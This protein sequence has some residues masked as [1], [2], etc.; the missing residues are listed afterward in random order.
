MPL[1]R[2]LTNTECSLWK[3]NKTINPLTK[4]KINIDGTIFKLIKKNCDDNKEPKEEREKERKEERKE[5]PQ[6]ECP[7]DK[8]LNPETKRCV[9]KTG[10]IGKRLIQK[11]KPNNNNNNSN[12]SNNSNQSTNSDLKTY[13]YTDMKR[14]KDYEKIKHFFEQEGIKNKECIYPT[15]KP[16]EYT[17]GTNGNIHLY[18]QIGRSSKYGVI[19]KCRYKKELPYFIGKIQVDSRVSS[20]ELIILEQIS[21]YAIKYKVANLPII[22]KYVKCSNVKYSDNQIGLK[23]PKTIINP[24]TLKVRTYTIIFNEIGFGDLK[25]FI[26]ENIKK[27][28]LKLVRN[29]TA[30]IF[31]SLACIHSLG[32]IHNDSHYGNFLYHKIKRG[33]CFHY[34]INGTDYYI[35]NMG[36]LWISWDYG[37]SMKNR[38]H[39]MY[40]IDYYRITYVIKKTL[41]ELLGEMKFNFLE[42]INDM[43]KHPEEIYIPVLKRLNMGEND[44][45]KFLLDNN[46]LFSK[47]PIGNVINSTTLNFREYTGN[48][49]YKETDPPF[50][51]TYDSKML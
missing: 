35:E 27:L 43:I 32:I 41:K 13:T 24:F 37:I 21:K 49:L 20:K 26:D 7:P 15:Q 12:N 33:G 51:I 1:K 22:Y 8:I 50:Y 3:N 18:K 30:Q 16:N 14:F 40:L 45:L 19:F 11:I 4:R 10:A 39:G 6:K 9:L 2:N 31:M 5:E 17:L 48:H 36:Y 29:I 34:N 23:L 38:N 25:T 46:L 44:F 42:I 28:D 47:V